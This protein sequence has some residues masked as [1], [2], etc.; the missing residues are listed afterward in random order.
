MIT[1]I[2][3]IR[4]EHI[5]AVIQEDVIVSKGDWVRVNGRDVGQAQMVTI[6]FGE[7]ETKKIVHVRP[8]MSYPK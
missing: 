4:D 8:D 6:E 5:L 3:D 2:K 7:D 1:F